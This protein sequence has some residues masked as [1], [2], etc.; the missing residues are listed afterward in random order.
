MEL[1]RMSAT[2]DFVDSIT[3]KLEDGKNI[4]LENAYVLTS[5]A[6]RVAVYCKMRVYLLPRYDYSVT[7]WKHLHAFIEDYCSFVH[8]YDAK[9][10]REI[11]SYGVID[12]ECEY[13]FASGIVTGIEPE[14]CKCKGCVNWPCVGVCGITE[15][16]ERY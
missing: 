3:L 14:Y 15:H 11:A 1:R 6:S 7:T 4:H 16:L 5:Y 9:T 13:A 2:V 10:I 12:T 8:D